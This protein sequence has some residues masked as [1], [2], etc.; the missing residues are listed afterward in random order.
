MRLFPNLDGLL[1]LADRGDVDIRPTLLRVLTDLYV[2]KPAHSRQEEQHYTELALRLIEAV[3]VA[4][5]RAVSMRLANYRHAPPAVIER[6]RRDVAEVAAPVLAC[7]PSPVERG[8][9]RDDIRHPAV[10]RPAPQRAP[11]SELNETFFSADAAERRLILLNLDYVSSTLPPAM[12]PAHAI[13]AMRALEQAALERNGAEF[14]GHLG[15]LLGLPREQT[16]RIVDDKS[17]EPLVVAM[18]AISMPAQVLQRILLFL[19]P[20]IGHSVQRVF[21]LSRLYDEIT[22]QAAQHLVAIWR[23]AAPRL[24]RQAIY[25]PVHWDDEAGQRRGAAA[26]A[27]RRQPDQSTGRPETHVRRR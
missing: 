19:N 2:Q 24:R 25:Q 10:P 9:D 21:D 1:G 3:D 5:R 12:P 26:T 11:A 18:K 15:R 22:A 17:G 14:M 20:A 16:R 8:A 23:G 4:T 13:E 27:A 7:A 6:L